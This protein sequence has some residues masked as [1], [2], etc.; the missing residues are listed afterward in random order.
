[1]ARTQNIKSNGLTYSIALMDRTAY[2][3]SAR[4]AGQIWD[5]GL[6]PSL[7]T[8][9]ATDR[10]ST[11]VNDQTRAGYV[12]TTLAFIGF[13]FRANNTGRA[14]SSGRTEQPV[15]NVKRV[16]N[17]TLSVDLTLLSGPGAIG[18]GCIPR[19]DF[20]VD[21]NGDF[22]PGRSGINIRTILGYEELTRSG[23]GGIIALPSL[24]AFQALR[25]GNGVYE[26]ALRPRMLAAL[27]RAMREK[28]VFGLV[29]MP[30][31]LIQRSNYSTAPRIT[32]RAAYAIKIDNT[33]ANSPALT[34]EYVLD[35]NRMNQG[36]G[37]S[38]TT[39]SGFMEGNVFSGTNSGFGD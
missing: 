9:V 36:G 31:Q 34:I 10:F 38:R 23:D 11:V 13:D 25:G 37:L 18:F 19:A 24:T 14:D 28:Q 12:S 15:N 39:T 7:P 17:A 22:K 3:D 30:V 1:M 21:R 2:G 16:M 6:G 4:Q 29:G 20:E 27:K 5:M 8:A 32:P 26:F 33:T 35:N